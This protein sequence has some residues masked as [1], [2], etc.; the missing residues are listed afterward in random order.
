M[1]LLF[2]NWREYLKEEESPQTVYHGTSLNRWNKL[3]QD[4]YKTDLLYFAT[5]P[6]GTDMYSRMAVEND[7]MSGILPEDNPAI[8]V[9]LD[10]AQLEANGELGR[11]WD[12]TPE[13][14]SWEES[15]EY[16]GTASFRGNLKNA[17]KKVEVFE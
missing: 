14:F 15:I 8:M 11:D 4:G 9:H 13:G 10:L 5:D 6:D 12:D 17:I 1:K 3:K 16:G 2:E 7:E